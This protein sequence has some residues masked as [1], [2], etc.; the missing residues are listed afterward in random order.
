M[1]HADRTVPLVDEA[2]T[3][4]TVF[5]PKN[6]NGKSALRIATIPIEATVNAF[7]ASIMLQNQLS[8]QS[9]ERK[10]LNNSQSMA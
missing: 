1:K 4:P 9:D 7:N 8:V 3:N 5:T 6:G 10:M 2:Q